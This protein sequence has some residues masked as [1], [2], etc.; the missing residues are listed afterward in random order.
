[1][2]LGSLQAEFNMPNTVALEVFDSAERLQALESKLR[3]EGHLIVQR[4]RVPRIVDVTGRLFW[5]PSR[6]AV[7]RI[8]ALRDSGQQLTFANIEGRDLS[9]TWEQFERARADENHD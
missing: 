8:A 1:M 5:P 4:I 6:D 7:D 3:T 2:D 9:R